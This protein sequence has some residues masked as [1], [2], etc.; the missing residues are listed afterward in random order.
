MGSC[1][2]TTSKEAGG[3]LEIQATP[4]TT[5]PFRSSGSLP[6]AN[7]AD[8]NPADFIVSGK[9]GETIIRRCGEVQGQSF[10]IEELTGCT[11]LVLD[12]SEQ[13]TI[14]ECKDC[15]IFVAACCSSVFIRDCENCVLAVCCQQLRTRDVKDSDLLV[16]STTEPI[17]ESSSELRIGCLDI[18][19]FGHAAHLDAARLSPW[20]NRFSEIHDFTPPDGATGKS[21]TN[22]A[23]PAEPLGQDESLLSEVGE[24]IDE[25]IG[26]TAERGLLAI[27]KTLGVRCRKEHAAVALLLP[28]CAASMGADLV[29]AVCGKVC[30]GLTKLTQSRTITLTSGQSKTL[31][32]K[33]PRAAAAAAG[34]PC[35]VLELSGADAAESV[36]RALAEAGAEAEAY[37]VWSGEESAPRVRLLFEELRESAGSALG[38]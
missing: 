22:W 14:D 16:F 26:L 1:C 38:C 5:V 37:A 9:T 25:T 10:A 29:D 8:L 27:P 17:I 20:D 2:S 28:A 33:R 12:H 21:S 3:G 32:P 24:R 34:S 30:T 11:V 4:A 18:S 13:V 35:L 6:Q 15:K 31:F 19:Y 23:P 7:A 36:T